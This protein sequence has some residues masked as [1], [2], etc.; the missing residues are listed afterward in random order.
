MNATLSLSPQLASSLESIEGETADAKMLS[1]LESY[2]TLR[3]HECEAEIT[4]Y[5]IKYRRTFADFAGAWAQ[6]EIARRHSHEVERDYME[7]EGLVAE[8]QRW[9]EQLRAL[10]QPDTL[11][12]SA[13]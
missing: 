9:L 3:L 4:Q 2:L 1:L 12:A 7:W 13:A 5:E 11:R 10:P 6:G 8:K